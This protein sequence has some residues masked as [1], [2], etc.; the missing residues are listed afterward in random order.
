MTALVPTRFPFPSRAGIASGKPVRSIQHAPLLDAM[1]YLR[2]HAR[3]LVPA[4]AMEY[5]L[6]A[7]TTHTYTIP[8]QLASWMTRLQWF[9]RMRVTTGTA[10]VVFTDPSGGTTTHTIGALDAEVYP[11]VS[12]AFHLEAITPGT[13]TGY[14]A[15]ARTVTFQRTDAGAGSVYIDTLACASLSRISLDYSADDLGV[16]PATVRADM[17]IV[18]ASYLSLGGV[19]A[20]M[21]DQ[22][23]TTGHG[24]HDRALF[25]WSRPQGHGVA[26]TSAWAD[27]FDEG[28]TV[29]ASHR[30]IGE[31]L[32]RIYCMATGKVTSSGDTLEVRFT[33]ASG[34][35]ATVNVTATSSGTW[36]TAATLDVYAEDLSTSDGRRSSTDEIVTIDARVTGAGA[37]TGSVEGLFIYESRVAT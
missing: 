32:R 34:D 4:T 13:D 11:R 37:N 35:T 19:A 28:P 18:D 15:P 21:A 20:L 29:Q 10:T 12:G 26:V 6:P 1:L 16:D 30:H 7:S 24:Y 9:L 33:A 17:P 22:D 31:T 14:A 8:M 36:G 23:D 27:L 25:A 3:V 5:A 2:G